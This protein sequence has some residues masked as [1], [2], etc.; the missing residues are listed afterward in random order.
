MAEPRRNVEDAREE[1][2]LLSFTV[3]PPNPPNWDLDIWDRDWEE[4]EGRG[5][6]L[7]DTIARFSRSHFCRVSE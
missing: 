1:T 7:E 6:R 5:M 2:E 3:L 4:V